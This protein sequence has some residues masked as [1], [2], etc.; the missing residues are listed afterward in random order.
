MPQLEVSTYT[1][2]IFW[3]I[4]T[5]M[6]FWFV[7]AKL[8]VPKIA[9][10][11][12]LRKRKYDD[13]ILKAEEINKKA[14]AVLKQY[15]ETLAVAK[16]DANEK[17]AANE[18]ELKLFIAEKEKEIDHQLKLKI[19]ENEALLAR[20]KQETLKRLDELSLNIAYQIVQ[21]L[22][23][24]TADKTSLEEAMTRKGDNIAN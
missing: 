8:I 1:T 20:E 5:F 15:E 22:E 13:Y 3:L 23:L 9:E 7:M 18:N 19:E 21:K 14:L 12:E 2:Q 24:Q 6:S 11:V 17:I 16:A 10:M 4:V